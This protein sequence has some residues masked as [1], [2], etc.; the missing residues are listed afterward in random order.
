MRKFNQNPTQL[1][2]HSIPSAFINLSQ[3]YVSV[4][5]L[6]KFFQLEE[7]EQA[8]EDSMPTLPPAFPSGTSPLTPNKHKV[9]AKSFFFVQ[10]TVQFSLSVVRFHGDPKGTHLKKSLCKWET[11]SW[12]PSWDELVVGNP[13]SLRPFWVK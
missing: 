13:V 4:K 11:E 1:Y 2:F 7:L 6:N 5:R 3:I 9:D 8:G 10:E 12:W